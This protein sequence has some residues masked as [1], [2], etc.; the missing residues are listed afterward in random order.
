M[1]RAVVLVLAL[2][3]CPHPHEPDE[4]R[5]LPAPAYAHYLRGRVAFDEGD[6]ALAATEL[7]A[8]ADAAPG[9]ARIEVERIRALA[10]AERTKDAQAAIAAAELRWPDS[11]DV[12]LIA[13][14][15]ARATDAAQPARA[16]YERAVAIDPAREQAYLGLA[17]VYVALHQD[18]LAE[19]TWRA[20]LAH[21]PDSIEGHFRLGERLA[22]QGDLRGAE[23][24]LRA[25]LERDPD[26]IDARLDLA[27]VR[28]Q[29]AR[30]PEAI[31]ET[32][33]AFDRA[34][35]TADIGEELF[36]LLL[37]S[38]DRAGAL[39]LLGLFDGPDVAPDARVVVSRLYLAID[40]TASARAQAEAALAAQPSSGEAAVA[41]AR[42]LAA[43]HDR[44]GAKAAVE[45]VA[46]GSPAYPAAQAAIAQLA[47][48][49]G[50]AAKALAVIEPMRAAHP[51][52]PTILSIHARALAAS[53][54]PDDARAAI[55]AALRAKPDDAALLYV[56]AMFEHDH[57]QAD[58][59]VQIMGQLLAAH[60]DYV[61]AL[62]WLGF[63][64]AGRR[65]D[66]PR[67]EK[68]LARA[69]TLAPGDPLI[70]DSW[71]WLLHV[72]GKDAAARAALDRAA[73]TAP[74][75]PELLL[76]LGE[77]R[78]ALGDAHGARTAL[79]AARALAPPADLEQR[80]D[81][82]LAALP[83]GS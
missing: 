47:L 20:L 61:D 82:R 18:A 58:R 9:E 19:R 63:E 54:K 35:G 14:D 38:D 50:D 37:E 81:A 83:A 56:S 1:K 31:A 48:D 41:L 26:H 60:P 12:W 40:E 44:K 80:I 7:R 72:E 16:A 76:H 22:D 74:R 59:A 43:A 42:A 11:A 8:A 24:Q 52:D 13:G 55:A 70:L 28:R 2:A 10:K 65:T 64:L 6:F 33:R 69:R 23:A 49:D 21:V 46:V 29:T 71:G 34:G 53:G 45:K 3:G 25:V 32:R 66:L 78:A 73:R 39:D 57:G 15:F 77:V 68:L 30:L 51:D 36:W 62:N 5:A 79:E 75:E 17:Q 67:A 4:P 27:H